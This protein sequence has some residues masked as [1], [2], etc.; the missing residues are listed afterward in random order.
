MGYRIEAIEWNKCEQTADSFY[1]DNKYLTPYS[2]YS[3][4]SII[5]NSA[6]IHRLKE[7]FRYKFRCYE[8]IKEN[9]VIMI[10]PLMVSEKDK[11]IR[12]AGDFSSVG[13]LD[14]LYDKGISGNDFKEML[15]LLGKIYPQ[16]TLK[17]NRISEFSLTFGFLRDMY[18]FTEKD[19][20]VKIDLTD[21]DQW[22]SGLKKNCRQNIR[23]SY[24]RLN[25]DNRKMQ[26]YCFVK[27][28]PDKKLWNDNI[29]LFA[30]RILEHT[31]LSGVFQ[32]P[33]YLL[34]K[35]EALTRALYCDK[36]IFFSSVYIEN[37]LAASCNG[38][39]AN[40]GRAIITRLSI[41]TSMA[42]YSPGGL[43]INEVIKECCAKY[44][45]I[46]SIDLSRG[47]EP[48]KYTYGGT[49]HF[50]YSYNLKL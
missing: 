36:D 46:K 27:Q 29:K 24:N 47:D 19:I 15:G 30:K 1:K 22:Y 10:I 45:F 23:T 7:S 25:T 17:L 21:Y 35:G 8:L 2:R 37:T 34:K 48:Y 28:K 3:F 38:V 26:F 9:S 5:K 20:C 16:Y 31:K 41:N 12:L 40:D 33:M 6:N 43:L 42:R 4:L 44:P 32:I 50:N 13:H 11:I 39:V 18:E 49:E 14:F